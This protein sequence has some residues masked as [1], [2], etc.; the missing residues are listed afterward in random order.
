MSTKPGVTSLPFASI[1]SAPL[2][3]TSPT[4]AMRLPVIPTSASTGARPVPS[5]TVPPRMTRSNSDCMDPSWE[6]VAAILGQVPGGCKRR[7]SYHQCAGPIALAGSYSGRPHC[8]A[9]HTPDRLAAVPAAFDRVRRLAGVLFTVLLAACATVDSCPLVPLAQAPLDTRGNLMFVA[10]GING[11]PVRFLVDTGAERTVLTETAVARLGL[12][13]DPQHVSRTIGIGGI[14]AN[15]DALLPGIVMGGTR[16]PLDRVAVG[17]FVFDHVPG[18]QVDGLLGAD[19]L[20]AFD[21]DI[22]QAAHQLTLYR[23]RRCPDAKPPWTEPSVQ[24]EGVGARRDRLL[25]PIVLDGEPGMAVLDTGAQAS[26]V[27]MALAKR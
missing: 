12:P 7:P 16:F 1:S 2:P 18:P 10:A 3:A 20:L 4:A 15:R 23:V 5:M 24:I 8:R 13:H 14:S 11:R 17:H 6:F 26:T 25:V 9:M 21:M 22:D 27:D 19:I